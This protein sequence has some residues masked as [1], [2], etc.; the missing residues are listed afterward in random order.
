MIPNNSK[1]QKT[2]I[3]IGGLNMFEIALLEKESSTGLL[4]SE[5]IDLFDMLDS[6]EAYPI[7]ISAKSHDSVAMGW[8]TPEAAE[9][10]D[11][12]YSGL[13][14]FVAN[15]LDDMNNE[16]EDGRYEFNELSIYLSRDAKGGPT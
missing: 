10:L 3:F 11:Y 1:H 13:E 7:E 6:T 8:I 12:I 16:T 2:W 9:K 15:I 14:D 5:V 4:R